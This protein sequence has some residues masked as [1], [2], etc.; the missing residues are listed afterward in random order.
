[1]INVNSHTIRDATPAVER[2]VR[3]AS[4]GSGGP[5]WNEMPRDLR[6]ACS[7]P[8]PP[9]TPALERDTSPDERTDDNKERDGVT[10]RCS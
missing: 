9:R 6:P 5:A 7:A 3:D 8:A 10:S 4:S 1:M 2:E